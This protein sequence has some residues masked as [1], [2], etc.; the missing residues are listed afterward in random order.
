MLEELIHYNIIKKG[1]FVLKSG[2]HSIYYINLKEALSYPELLDKLCNKLAD[3]IVETI[4]INNINDTN[5]YAI[6]GIPDGAIP[7]ASIISNKL[8]IPMLLLRK[9]AK[10]HGMCAQI[11]GCINK[12]TKIIIIEDVVTTG[13]SITKYYEILKESGYNVT[14]IFSFIKRNNI[15]LK[16]GNIILDSILKIDDKIL[17]SVFKRIDEEDTLEFPPYLRLY[18][19]NL[20]N[21]KHLCVAIDRTSRAEFIDIFHKVGP[22]VKIIKTHIDIIEDFTPDFIDKLIE[23]KKQYKVLLWEDRKF[24]DIGHIVTSQLDRGIYKISTWADIVS[25]HLIAGPEILSY[26]KNCYIVV[27][28]SMSS[29]NTFADYEYAFKCR[30]CLRNIIRY[31]NR[32]VG[33]VSQYDLDLG[34]R[35]LNIVPGLKLTMSEKHINDD[36]DQEYSEIKNKEFGNIFV[37]GRDIINSNNISEKCQEYIEY[38]KCL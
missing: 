27:V 36:Y 34:E 9:E 33:V 23:L 1:E 13:K 15:E 26:I 14:N 31:N 10:Q 16:C 12:T 5:N 35:I 25:V 38:I 30:I 7:F 21:K 4:T 17:N 32:I 8:K 22:Y 19:N 28:C 6:C 37:V 24:A 2:K 11:E 20:F 29:K 3:T 18:L